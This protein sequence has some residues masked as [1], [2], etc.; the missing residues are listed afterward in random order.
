MISEK[1]LNLFKT[2]EDG[3]SGTKEYVILI[4][5]MKNSSKSCDQESLIIETEEL[6]IPKENIEKL[7]DTYNK[8]TRELEIISG[9]NVNSDGMYYGKLMAFINNTDEEDYETN[10]LLSHDISIVKATLA[11]EINIEFENSFE[12]EPIIHITIDKQYE[13]LYRDW[14]T[15]FIKDENKKISGVKLVF[16]SLK[17]RQAYPNIGVIIIGEKNEDYYDEFQNTIKMTFTVL[18]ELTEENQDQLREIKGA[19]IEFVE[20]NE[21][22]KTNYCGQAINFIEKPE[23]NEEYS[24]IVTKEGYNSFVTTYDC[25][26]A[27]IIIELQKIQPES[28]EESSNIR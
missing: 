2:R 24:I 7:R 22:L 13:S 20:Q 14:S 10:E 5:D 18:E 16:K 23:E 4:T 25:T 9:I 8:K 19:N 21:N 11:N 26:E 15:E 1:I 28:I 6:R 3:I 17:T 27:N 12:E